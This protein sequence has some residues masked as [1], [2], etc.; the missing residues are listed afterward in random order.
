MKRMSIEGYTPMAEAHLKKMEA[1]AAVAAEL[2]AE[3]RFRREI[4]EQELDET[5]VKLNRL[6]QTQR[7]F[8]HEQ[9]AHNKLETIENDEASGRHDLSWQQQRRLLRE[10]LAELD[11]L[12]GLLGQSIKEHPEKVAFRAK[13]A[14]KLEDM[15][16]FKT[17][18]HLTGAINELLDR[19]EIFQRVMEEAWEATLSDPKVRGVIDENW[20]QFYGQAERALIN[21]MKQEKL[22]RRS[23]NEERA[24]LLFILKKLDVA[25]AIVSDEVAHDM[26]TF[27]LRKL[28]EFETSAEDRK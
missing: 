9:S 23:P 25:D 27:A 19:P 12:F 18:K 6:T 28:R 22:K 8:I 11:S 7:E 17:E 21:A 3:D 2:R 20:F 5:D 13:I 26:K 15:D 1:D 4:G 10:A 24:W 14:A 16:R